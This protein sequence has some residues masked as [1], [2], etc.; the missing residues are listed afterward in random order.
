MNFSLGNASIGARLRLGFGAMVLLALTLAAQ[1]FW[2]ARSAS[3]QLRQI[4]SVNNHR[5]ELANGL[6]D[7]ISRLGLQARNLA[8]LTESKDV[9]AAL[10]AMNQSK[11][12]YL[13]L[14]KELSEALAGA[15]DQEVQLLD[16][17]AKARA[18]T[19]PGIEIAALQGKSGANADAAQTLTQD[20]APA[21]SLWRQKIGELASVEKSFNS[22]A[23]E[24]MRAGQNRALATGVLLAIIA[25]ALGIGLAWTIPRSVT[26]P[27]DQAVEFA[28]RIARGDLSAAA[29]AHEARG[30]FGRLNHALEKMQQRLRDIVTEISG[31]AESIM[32]ASAEVAGGNQDLSQRTE[33]TALN[34][35]SATSSMEQLT[36]SVT[37]SATSANRATQLAMQA[38]QVATSGG[39]VVTQMVSTMEEINVSSRRIVDI[40][41]VID[42]IAFQTNILALNAAVEAARAGE[43]GR[44]FAV[45]AAEVR[46]LAQRSAQAAREIK[47]LIDTSV[48]KVD[49][50]AGLVGNAGQ[51]ME[52]IL[53][54][55]KRVSDIINE[56]ASVAASQSD[57][58]GLINS[59]VAQLD[60][61]TQQN[62]ALVEQSAAAAE[63]L[64]DQAGRLTQMVGKFRLSPA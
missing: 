38:F 56:I 61:M 45:V 39:V 54:S 36:D 57:G 6:Q 46:N 42:G 59:T 62:A 9:E 33:Q 24:Q 20:V 49:I 55:V 18:K 31:S 16:A 43:Q 22:A 8:L 26:G 21:E 29:G 13:A 17:I 15:G 4:V 50:G 30:E 10:A 37:H 52:E 5:V 1:G 53:G 51:S 7:E 58:I 28:E 23:L 19:L 34:L 48:H 63:S 35:Q 27:V 25:L 12:H 47:S 40:I 2:T 3:E 60:Q 14:E 64:K 41:G 44:G 11:A 32:V